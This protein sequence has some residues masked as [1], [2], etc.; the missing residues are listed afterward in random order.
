MLLLWHSTNSKLCRP[1]KCSVR[2]HCIKTCHG[3]DV[4][5]WS[6]AW[7]KW[8][9]CSGKH[10]RMPTEW[11]LSP[12]MF[13]QCCLPKSPHQICIF[14][15][16]WGLGREKL[17]VRSQSFVHHLL[18]SSVLYLGSGSQLVMILWYL[19]VTLKVCLHEMWNFIEANCSQFLS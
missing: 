6:T 15:L 17:K 4:K 2:Q 13:M 14:M 12:W 11:K 1:L 5:L 19:L 16:R 3:A 10:Q 9:V 18:H 7:L 8:N